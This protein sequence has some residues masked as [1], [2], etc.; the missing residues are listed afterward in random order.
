MIHNISHRNPV[1]CANVTM[2]TLKSLFCNYCECSSV[3]LWFKPSFG[4]KDGL[5]LN[6]MCQCFNAS[7]SLIVL[8]IVF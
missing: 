8:E 5:T 1:T 4:S 7:M 6:T 3:W 2:T